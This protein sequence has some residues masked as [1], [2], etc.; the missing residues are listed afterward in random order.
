MKEIIQSYE[1]ARCRQFNV[2]DFGCLGD[3]DAAALI[4]ALHHSQW[5]T[6]IVIRNLKL[7][8]AVLTSLAL[9]VE[10]TSSLQE[11][12]LSGIGAKSD[13][14]VKLAEAMAMNRQQSINVL[15]FSHNR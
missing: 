12:T 5:F 1:D 6:S 10:R 9:L 8:S 7:S 14:W 4:T 13:F 11:L 2:D 3:E 15:D